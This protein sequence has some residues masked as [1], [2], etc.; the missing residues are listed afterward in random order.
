M[1][2]TLQFYIF[3]V[4]KKKTLL[5]LYYFRAKFVAKRQRL[6]LLALSG[7]ALKAFQ[8]KAPNNKLNIFI[9]PF[10]YFPLWLNIV[11]H[12]QYNLSIFF[13]NSLTYI[14]YYDIIYIKI[15]G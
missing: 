4:T 9:P 11:Y 14:I 10:N 12:Q 5:G 3:Y 6:L 7:V 2:I 1:Q 8:H 13:K 15:G